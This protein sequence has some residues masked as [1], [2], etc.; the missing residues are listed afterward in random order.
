MKI[1][2]ILDD[3][4]TTVPQ[5]RMERMSALLQ[6]WER[7]RYWAR[8]DGTRS[9]PSFDVAHELSVSERA[10]WRVLLSRAEPIPPRSLA[11]ALIR[12]LDITKSP[13]S[14]AT[15]VESDAVKQ[16][17]NRVAYPGF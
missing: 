1:D 7:P 6:L 13:H 15:L 17:G 11:S 16:I 4:Y 14:I 8:S 10:S 12:L 9:S 3:E 2:N 5:G